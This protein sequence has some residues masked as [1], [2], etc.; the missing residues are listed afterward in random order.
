MP[1][2]ALVDVD[3][4][5]DAVVV[6]VHG[7]VDMANVEGVRNALI[8]AFDGSDTRHIVDLSDTT[9]L[10]SVGV[11][12]LV[13]I[14]HG[15]RTRRRDMRIVVPESSPVGR[16]LSLMDVGHVVP[17]YA[18]METALAAEDLAL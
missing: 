6:R 13:S 15:L 14:A 1:E 8:D 18:D 9:F 12:L 11:H 10:D 16:V 5:T 2:Q 17:M 4:R 3:H 7:D